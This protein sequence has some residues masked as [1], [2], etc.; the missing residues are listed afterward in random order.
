MQVT[1]DL[2]K[3]IAKRS[4]MHSRHHLNSQTPSLSATDG[5]LNVKTH[6]SLPQKS[7]FSDGVLPFVPVSGTSSMQ[8]QQTKQYA[9]QAEDVRVMH[10]FVA[11][12]LP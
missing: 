4:A 12:N 9:M 5:L 1:E 11:G 3:Q 8:T 6:E 7:Q 10:S 2:R